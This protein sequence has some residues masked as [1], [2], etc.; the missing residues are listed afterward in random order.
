M[1]LIQARDYLL[2]ANESILADR[3]NVDFSKAIAYYP[4]LKNSK[5]LDLPYLPNPF[6]HSPTI[7]W[8]NKRLMDFYDI[9]PHRRNNEHI[10]LLRIKSLLNA[11]LSSA[12]SYIE[13]LAEMANGDLSDEDLDRA[14][15]IFMEGYGIGK[16]IHHSMPIRFIPDKRKV[17]KCLYRDSN[18]NQFVTFKGLRVGDILIATESQ[19]GLGGWLNPVPMCLIEEG[20]EYKVTEIRKNGL[21]EFPKI[22]N[23][24]G[25]SHC[26]NFN[27]FKLKEDFGFYKYIDVDS[28]DKK[29]IVGVYEY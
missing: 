19:Q 2:F 16:S 20:K 3:D 23:E 14:V 25:N 12:P 27:M 26:P 28:S 6:I 10:T 11:E 17:S 13:Q 22:V 21:Y 1:K 5:K 9:L 29:E 18:Y 8:I 24:D 7:D 4:L 15:N